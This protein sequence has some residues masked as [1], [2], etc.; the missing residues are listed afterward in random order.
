MPAFSKTIIS[1]YALFFL[2]II[3]LLGVE[4]WRMRER[5]ASASQELEKRNSQVIVFVPQKDIPAG[6]LLDSVNF[7]PIYWQRNKLKK[8]MLVSPTEFHRYRQ[9]RTIVPLP[10]RKIVWRSQL[11]DQPEN[12]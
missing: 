10:A 5:H 6:A 4:E 7:E 1:F 3:V 2:L 9:H 12:E 11:T 8:D